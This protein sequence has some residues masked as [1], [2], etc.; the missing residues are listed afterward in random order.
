MSPGR[1][2]SQ[3]R[4]D[5]RYQVHLGDPAPDVNAADQ[6]TPSAHD[7]WD[8]DRRVVNEYTVADLTVVTEALSVIADHDHQGLLRE[9][10]L[11]ERAEQPPQLRVVERDLSVVRIACVRLCIR[12]G[13]LVH[14]VRVVVLDPQEERIVSLPTQ[15]LEGAVGGPITPSFGT[16]GPPV[17]LDGFV[18]VH[19]EALVQSEA[20]VQDERRHHRGGGVSAGR[21]H[22]GQRRLLGTQRVEP[23][24]ARAVMVWIQ[25]GQDRCV[26][27]QRGGRGGEG[28]GE[29]HPV[30]GQGVQ[31]RGP[32]LA[33]P[34]TAE[35]IRPC[36][37]EGDQQQTVSRQVAGLGRQ[38]VRLLQPRRNPQRVQRNL[39]EL[40]FEAQVSR[41]VVRDRGGDEADA[42]RPPPPSGREK[43]CSALHCRR[44]S[45]TRP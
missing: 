31:D 25:P 44:R 39:E 17:L 11:V 37:I 33:V 8:P 32:D 10:Q 28:V 15:P 7:E 21:Q 43:A 41:E 23:V 20:G 40:G 5:R 18:V 9:P 6:V 26:G 3:Q 14:D 27:G 36:R 1:R 19:V 30:A 24:G 12:S 45:I 22:L 42:D 38:R 13:R 4:K 35:P 16:A 29:D 34:V 2:D